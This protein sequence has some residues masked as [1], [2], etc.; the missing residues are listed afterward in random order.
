MSYSFMVVL[1]TVTTP[2][3]FNIIPRIEEFDELVVK[4]KIENK[5]VVIPFTYE[6]KS[7][8]TEITAELELIEGRDYVFYFK[9]NGD[10]SHMEKVFCTDQL[11]YSIN[12]GVYEERETPNEFLVYE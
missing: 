8:Y 7:Y 11:D 9:L 4:D 3:A 2:Q 10:V 1:K 12:N 6:I 5:S